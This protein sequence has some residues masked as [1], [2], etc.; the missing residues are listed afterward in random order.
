MSKISTKQRPAKMWN[1]EMKRVCVCVCVYISDSAINV[2]NCKLRM[3]VDLWDVTPCESWRTD[4]SEER[5][6]S[7]EVPPKRWFLQNPHGL[8]YKKTDFFIVTAL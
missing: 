4:A 3:I 1:T 8:F 2:C 6:A 5:V 7:F